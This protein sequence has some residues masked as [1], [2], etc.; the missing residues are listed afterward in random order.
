MLDSHGVEDLGDLAAMV[1]AVGEGLCDAADAL[2][3]AAGSV[4]VMGLVG[5]AG[6]E[7]IA[8]LD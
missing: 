4:V 6:A 5:A 8:Q 2:L 3:E 1:D 7:M